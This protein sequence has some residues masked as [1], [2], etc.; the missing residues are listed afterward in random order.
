MEIKTNE[1]M[2]GAITLLT[3]SAIGMCNA[4]DVE[5]VIKEFISSKDILVAL[6]QYNTGRV[7]SNNK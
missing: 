5:E 3:N 4:K 6:Y 2:R 1:D 7:S